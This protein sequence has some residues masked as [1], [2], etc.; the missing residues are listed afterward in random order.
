MY[1][2]NMNDIILQWDVLNNKPLILTS[3]SMSRFQPMQPGPVLMLDYL[4][5]DLPLI[6]TA[7]R[8]SRY[9][10]VYGIACHIF[11]LS[12]SIIAISLEKFT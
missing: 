8:I 9:F 6:L 11:D 4:M 5:Y 12:N 1:Y 2:L 3:L 7:V 10:R